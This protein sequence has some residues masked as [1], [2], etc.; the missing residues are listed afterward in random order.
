MLRSTH[1]IAAGLALALAACAP[2]MRG[3]P[4]LGLAYDDSWDR[5]ADGFVSEVELAIAF[6]RTD[7]FNAW[8]RDDDRGLDETEL[9]AGMGDTELD[10]GSWEAWDTDRDQRIWVDEF[11]GGFFR[12]WDVNSDGRLDPE[13]LSDGVE[14][15]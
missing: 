2:G 12:M 6:D 10:W 3:D 14:L 1:F 11:V 7:A 15:M 9:Y 8:D 4:A 5:D 13:E